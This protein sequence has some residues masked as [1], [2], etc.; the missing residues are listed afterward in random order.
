MKEVVGP[1]QADLEGEHELPDFFLESIVER[2]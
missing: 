1:G 2:L